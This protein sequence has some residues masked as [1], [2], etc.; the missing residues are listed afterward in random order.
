VIILAGSMSSCAPDAPQPEVAVKLEEG[1]FTAE[2]D[3]FPI[4]YEVHGRGPVLM[5]VPNSWGLSL[6]GLRA[7]YRPLEERLTMVYFDPRGMGESGAVREESDM[8]M[9]AVRADFEALRRH[10][11][12]ET[13]HAIGWSNGASNLILLAAETPQS[14]ASAIFVHGV[15][16]FTEEDMAD[17]G[18]RYPDLMQRYEVF[19]QEVRDPSL[20]ESERTALQRA[21]WL[22]EFFPLMMADPE[23]GPALLDAVYS[24][25]EFSWAHA[26]YANR[27]APVFDAPEKVLELHNG[28][29]DSEFVVF[30]NSGHF[31]PVEET[32]AFKAAV[33]GFLGVE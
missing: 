3:G 18:A 29:P 4:H 5:T 25:A 33:Y 26:D 31:A 1:S 17:F 14:L 27:E 22:E 23:G 13:V 15:A 20:E 19:Q 9:A 28:L 16:S 30:G 8:G 6:A 21:L 32:E 24:Q 12:L 2:L 10:L 7:F 11:E